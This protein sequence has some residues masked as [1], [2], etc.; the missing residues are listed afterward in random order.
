[1]LILC[2]WLS[3]LE[4]ES[5]PPG[6]VVVGPAALPDGVVAPDAVGVAAGTAPG[7]AAYVGRLLQFVLNAYLTRRRPRQHSPLPDRS[8]C[9]CAAFRQLPPA[10]WLNFS[11]FLPFYRMKSR[12][13]LAN[14]NFTPIQL[15]FILVTSNILHLLGWKVQLIKDLILVNPD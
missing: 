14:F 5:L 4:P 15:N 2:F 12:V 6:G 10:K 11:C 7:R 9:L 13:E 1:M 3:E 8:H